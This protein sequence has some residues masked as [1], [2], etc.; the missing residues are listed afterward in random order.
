MKDEPGSAVAG[1]ERLIPM[2]AMIAGVW[3]LPVF[4][5]DGFGFRMKSAALSPV[6]TAMPAGLVGSLSKVLP[7]GRAGADV[8]S[9]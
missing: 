2:Q 4:W 1:A 6:S 3:G 8:P 5:G 7:L 9:K